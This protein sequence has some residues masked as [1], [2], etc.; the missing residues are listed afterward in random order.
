[1]QTDVS[2]Q[3]VAFNVTDRKQFNEKQI[4]AAF[5]EQEFPNVQVVK[6]P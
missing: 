5:K 6:R 1:V 3:Q 2:K 4:R